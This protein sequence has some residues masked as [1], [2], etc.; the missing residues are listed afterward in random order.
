MSNLAS[1]RAVI[2]GRVQGVYFRAFV[3]DKAALLGL[4]GSVRNLDGGREVE[5]VAEGERAQLEQLIGYL[6]KGPP[7][8]LVESVEISW[9]DFS[10]IYATFS[11]L[12]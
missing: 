11:I 12:Y 9:A 2:S 3:A 8:S 5:V 7:A 6:K 10:S 4:N 1:F